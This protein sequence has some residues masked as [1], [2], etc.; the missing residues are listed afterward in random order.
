VALARIRDHLAII[1]LSVSLAIL[2]AAG[3]FLWQWINRM[4]QL[5][6]QTDQA[7]LIIGMRN[8]RRGISME[9]AEMAASFRPMPRTRT[10]EA[11]R[12]YV[13]E[14]YSQWKT[15][16]RWPG[17]IRSVSVAFRSKDGR[18]SFET[19]VPAT[20]DFSPQEWPESLIQFRLPLQGETSVSISAVGRPDPRFQRFGFPTLPHGFG[21]L[22]DE[23]HSTLAVPLFAPVEGKETQRDGLEARAAE[24]FHFFLGPPPAK[25]SQMEPASHRAARSLTFRIAN[26]QLTGWCFLHLDLADMKSRFI[27]ALVRQYLGPSGLAKYNVAIITG[28]ARQVIYSSNPALTAAAFAN[29]DAKITMLAPRPFLGFL[30]HGGRLG[31]GT[32][33][34]GAMLATRAGPFLP[35][36][37]RPG[38]PLPAW[39]RLASASPNAWL[40]VAKDKQGSIGTEVSRVR[41]RNMAIAFGTLI[42]LALSISALVVAVQRAHRLAQRQMVFVA[43]I[44]HE[45][46]TPLSVIESAAHNLAKG[47]VDNPER[48]QQYGQAIQTEG[49]RLSSLVQQTLGYAALQSGRQYYDFKPVSVREVVDRAWSAFAAAFKEGGWTVEWDVSEGIPQIQGDP[50]VLEGA[51]KN[52]FSNALKYASPGKWLRITARTARRW[53]GKEVVISVEDRGPGIDV[54]D[55]PHIFEPFYRGRKVVASPTSGVGLGLSLV[56]EHI[57]AHQ[58]Q[59]AAQ[60]V[61]P[62][63]VRFVLY[64]PCPGYASLERAH[65]LSDHGL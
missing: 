39:R 45:L 24:P 63:G 5:D 46:R 20:G 64:L 28:N 58:G 35:G 13:V 40:L 1:I 15:T 9:L 53:R 41:R 27:P 26:L 30:V 52:L 6:Q 8:L 56:A 49:R 47:L 38:P 17:L 36:R 50:F 59:V 25:V 51:L 57:S 4:S 2:A 34:G 7:D 16:T 44:S 10:A 23:D 65:Y 19:Y 29:A 60:N 43:G 32:P 22:L 11:W 48:V 61:K 54:G 55:L 12:T 62:K 42:L 18:I 31:T 14:S 37:D 21:T 3:V 33:G